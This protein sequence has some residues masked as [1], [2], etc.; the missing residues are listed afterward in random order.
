LNGF[1]VSDCGAIANIFETHRYTRTPED[2][3]AD[4]LHAGTD[5]ECG[6]YYLLHL[7]DAL[8]RKKIIE[9][10][11]DQALTRTF[12]VLIRLGWFDPPEQQIYRKLNKSN[13]D[14]LEARQLSLVSA[15]ES[16]VLLKNMN[17]TLP[18]NMDQLR[19]KKIALIG[20]M[21]D[22]TIAMQGNYY[23]RA[24]FLIDPITGFKNLTAGLKRLELSF[25][26]FILYY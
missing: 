14:T 13:V 8:D 6:I 1:I 25:F 18:L 4:A 20:P 7:H 16:I 3:V 21:A 26:L 22:A 2:A 5:L 15:Q 9:T 19:N 12:D 17:K 23:G 11:I 24:P 10:D